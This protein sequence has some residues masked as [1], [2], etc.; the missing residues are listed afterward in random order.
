MFNDSVVVIQGPSTQVEYAKNSFSGYNLI[1]STWNG[2]ESKYKESDLVIFNEMPE[3]K[4]PMNMNLQKITT[5]AGL[6]LAKKLGYKYALKI[7]SD[8]IPTDYL[9]LIELFDYTKLNIFA[10][11]HHR[12]FTGCPGYL[13][14]HLMFSDI[15]TLL[16]LWNIE[17]MTWNSVPEII[18]THQ[19]IQKLIHKIDVKYFINELTKENDLFWIK[20]NQYLSDFIIPPK[21]NPRDVHKYTDTKCF[22]NFDY[23]KFLFPNFKYNNI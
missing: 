11:Q 13:T 18:M 23:I 4:G 20:R 3:Y 6:Q 5:V 14:D 8:L 10:W 1:F 22:L 7:R 19:Y 21:Y 9:Q 12:V 15:D 17:D 16:D 2:S